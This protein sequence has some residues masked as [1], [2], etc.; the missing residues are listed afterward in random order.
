MHARLNFEGLQHA[1][2]LWFFVLQCIIIGATECVCMYM[3]YIY[4]MTNVWHLTQTAKNVSERKSQHRHE[5]VWERDI[6]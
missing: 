4:A 6:S 3:Y 5:T 1:V 2:A